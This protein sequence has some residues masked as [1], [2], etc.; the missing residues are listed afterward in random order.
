MKGSHYLSELIDLDTMKVNAINMVKAPT[1]S[2]KTYFALHSIPEK[3]FNT[4][5]EAVYLIDTINGK[6][7][8]LKNYNAIPYNYDWAREVMDDGQWFCKDTSIVI[9]T[10][11]KFGSLTM[12]YPSFENRFKYIICDELHNLPRFEAFSERPNYHSIAKTAI[13]RA[14]QNDTTIVVGLTAT[15]NR[16]KKTFG[17]E[18]NEVPIDQEK[19]RQYSVDEV[20]HY[21]DIA[22]VLEHESRDC[23]GLCFTPQIGK[24]QVIEQTAKDLGYS[25]ICIW[26]TENKDHP[27]NA[28]QLRVRDSIL[29]EY[30]LPEQ[31]NLL[32][33]NASS[34]TS[35]KIK[36]HIDYAIINSHDIDTQVQVRGRVN[37]DLE[38]V[39]LPVD[40]NNAII[41]VPDKY[42]GVKLFQPDRRKLCAEL[43]I[44]ESRNN[45]CCGWT[46]IHRL[47]Q[48]QDY[49]ITEG[50]E[51]NLR[52]VII[53]PP[54]QM[55]IVPL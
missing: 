2:G 23:T 4:I 47:L 27:M 33:I 19:V 1:G 5:H 29:N 54:S 6:E 38:C 53:T 41:T 42:L 55:C 49:I 17:V 21:T 16:V 36:S 39:Y 12:N 11:A 7:Q 20:Q 9:M 30:T 45:R 34:E 50:R 15:P 40:K 24:M 22:K 35:I 18:Y 26:S 43:N 44:R 31:Y 14:V 13:E 28:E 10:Y 25:P 8:I 46:T 51:D 48:D 32:I 52:Y 37:S 3:C